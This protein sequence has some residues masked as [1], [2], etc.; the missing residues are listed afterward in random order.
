M[1][2]EWP[3]SNGTPGDAERFPGCGGKSHLASAITKIGHCDEKSPELWVA[4]VQALPRMWMINDVSIV[5]CFH[6]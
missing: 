4:T 5:V 2:G 6:L 3:A 1:F